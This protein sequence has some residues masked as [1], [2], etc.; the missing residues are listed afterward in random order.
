MT[1]WQKFLIL[2]MALL[3]GSVVSILGMIHGYGLTVKSLAWIIAAQVAFPLAL[4][5]MLDQ[6]HKG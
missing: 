4:R 5:W 2:L 6:I 3:V 1:Q